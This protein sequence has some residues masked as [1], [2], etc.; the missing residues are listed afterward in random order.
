MDLVEEYVVRGIWTLHGDEWKKKLGVLKTEFASF[1]K[2]MK[3]V[4]DA[5]YIEATLRF[6]LVAACG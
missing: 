4:L 1:A 2:L 6:T 3:K 5:L